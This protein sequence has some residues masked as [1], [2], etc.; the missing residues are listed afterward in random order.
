MT[1]RLRRGR[2]GGRPRFV[3]T[4]ERRRREA[5]S[6]LGAGRDVIDLYTEVTIPELDRMFDQL[7]ELTPPPGA[8]ER[9]VEIPLRSR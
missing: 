1:S 4:A 6:D 3:E 7:A 9:V 5:G 8:E 2:P